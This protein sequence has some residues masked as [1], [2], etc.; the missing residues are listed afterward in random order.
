VNH[1]KP[2]IQILPW[3]NGIPLSQGSMSDRLLEWWDMGTTEV[4]GI[5]SSLIVV[6]GCGFPGP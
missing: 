6:S 3:N 4:P 2:V 1:F 5:D